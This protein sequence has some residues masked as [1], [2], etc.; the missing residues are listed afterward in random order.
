MRFSCHYLVLCLAFV[1]C[2][3]LVV[4]APHAAVRRQDD[5]P[6]AESTTEA[7]S[8]AFQRPSATPTPSEVASSRVESERASSTAAPS[9]KPSETPAP[10]TVNH[11]PTTI[12]SEESTPA[13]SPGKLC[14][15]R[16]G[17]IN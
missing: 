15:I 2:L 7:Q 14:R 3:Q 10:S 12:P 5:S 13:E 8:S 11:V 6:S 4:A 17:G 9:V 1:L 16:Y